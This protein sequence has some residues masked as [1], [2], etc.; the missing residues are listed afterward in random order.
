VCTTHSLFIASKVVKAAEA[1][2]QA[3]PNSTSTIQKYP[4]T[5][6]WIHCGG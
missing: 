3:K 2:N 6:L 5:A 4:L 1:H